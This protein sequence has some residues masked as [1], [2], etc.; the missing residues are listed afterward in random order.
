[1]SANQKRNVELM[2]RPLKL[3]RSTGY[4]VFDRQCSPN[5][6]VFVIGGSAG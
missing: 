3:S 2:L 5:A 6:D 1:M 4:T